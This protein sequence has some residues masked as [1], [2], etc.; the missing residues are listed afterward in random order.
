[1]NLMFLNINPQKKLESLFN[2]KWS[3]SFLHTEGDTLMN[4]KHY[5]KL[6]S[7]SDSL[8]GKKNL[9]SYI[10]EEAGRVFMANKTEELLQFNF[11][12]QRGDTMIMDFFIRIGVRY[13][14]RIDSVKSI[15]LHDQKE[16]IA[17]YVTVFDYHG[18]RLSGMSLNDVFVEGG[19]SLKFGIEYLMGLFV[20][21]SSGCWPT[22][23]CFYSGGGLVYANPE[24]NNCYLNTGISEIRQP[25]LA[26]VFTNRYGMLEIQLTKAK[27][28]KLFVFDL[29]GNEL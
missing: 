13:Y 5:K 19:G 16:R 1:M 12:L 11:N 2:Q 24:I 10:R 4:E 6:V 18:S 29:N 28:G 26:Q 22:L 9:K 14:I 20:T 23:L 8:C 17:Q 21:G 27:A 15:V 7:C 25:D 3:T